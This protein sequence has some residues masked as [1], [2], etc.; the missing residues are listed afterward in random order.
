MDKAEDRDVETAFHD[1]RE[2]SQQRKTCQN[3]NT[4]CTNSAQKPIYT[5]DPYTL[6]S[7]QFDFSRDS[8]LLSHNTPSQTNLFFDKSCNESIIINSSSSAPVVRDATPN[9]CT[10]NT[11]YV[12]V[13]EGN[14]LHTASGCKFTKHNDSRKR[15]L[16]SDQNQ[17]FVQVRPSNIIMPSGSINGLNVFT[18]P[19]VNIKQDKC[20]NSVVENGIPP[21]SSGT[22]NS[23]KLNSQNSYEYSSIIENIPR[24][25][26]K[27]PTDQY[28]LLSSVDNLSDKKID[29]NLVT[30]VKQYILN[31]KT[32]FSDNTPFKDISVDR[33]IN[34]R[35]SRLK[36]ERF[37]YYS[38]DS[39]SDEECDSVFNN[40]E[41][42]LLT[43]D[44]IANEEAIIDSKD[45]AIDNKTIMDKKETTMDKKEITM[46]K[47]GT[48]IDKKE[49]IIEKKEIT[50][51]KRETTID[52]KEVI[53]D[54][55]ETNIDKKEVI[56]DE[57]DRNLLTA[58]ELLEMEYKSEWTKYQITKREYEFMS[59]QLLLREK[60]LKKIKSL[61]GFCDCTIDC[62]ILVMG[63]KNNLNDSCCDK[64][65]IKEACDFIN[66]LF[67]GLI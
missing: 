36:K 19:F 9:Y 21:L 43:D 62:I 12:S 58:E 52:K 67:G 45:N 65:D 25:K 13:S 61:M 40:V 42:D 56:V 53:I 7:S 55:K 54:K 66:V 37:V 63:S 44:I 24:K 22:Q 28:L 50:I 38:D 5:I 59:E 20:V 15:C 33:N 18:T 2:M 26:Q 16:V 48:T 14:G 1:F 46:D 60:K 3:N 23:K 31:S 64:Y 49:T 47:K 8:I 30:M 32:S 35:Q 29:Q 6:H 17:Q 10:F 11:N 34:D 41:K 51:D 57:N 39:S 27:L 4:S